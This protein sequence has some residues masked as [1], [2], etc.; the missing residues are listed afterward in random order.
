MQVQA[1]RTSSRPLPGIPGP[2]S[3]PNAPPVVAETKPVLEAGSN[4]NATP[5]QSPF[6]ATTP[7]SLG[8][9]TVPTYEDLVAQVARLTSQAQSSPPGTS[10]RL[11]QS[12]TTTQSPS[13]ATTPSLLAEIVSQMAQMRQQISALQSSPATAGAPVQPTHTQPSGPD[14][15]PPYAPL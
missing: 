14:V 1:R 3:S 9:A 6:P 4:Q 5:P 12:P 2:A 15:P 8:A 11:P 13:S 7:S 10:S